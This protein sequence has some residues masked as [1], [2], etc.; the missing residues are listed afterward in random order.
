MLLRMT[1]P[2]PPA[3]EP[4]AT[5]RRGRPADAEIDE[6]VLAAGVAL[7][8]E[9]GWKAF[10]LDGVA[11]QAKVGKAALYRRWPT[12]EALITDALERIVVPDLDFD[13]GSLR[14]DLLALA[15]YIWQVSI[16]ATG[17]M[18]MRVAVEAHLEPGIFGPRLAEIV[19]QQTEVGRAIVRRAVARGEVPASISSRLVIHAMSGAIQNRVLY[20]TPD[21]LPDLEQHRDEVLAEVV[22]FVIAGMGGA[23]GG[24]DQ[25][26]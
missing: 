10:N 23:A 26:D 2:E 6:R 25:G 13:T 14:G 8:A 22:D 18:L 1:G 4:V 7:F 3:S 12:R 17:S 16:S 9:V 15:R 11:R 21:R 24:T 5:T 19:G 20:T